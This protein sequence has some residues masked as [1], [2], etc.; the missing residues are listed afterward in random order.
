QPARPRRGPPAAALAG[1]GA[2][3]RQHPAHLGQRLLAR[4]ADRAERLAGRLR[5]GVEHVGRGAGLDDDH[6]ESMG[7][8]VVQLAADPGLLLGD[9]PPRLQFRLPAAAPGPAP[10][11]T[12]IP[13]PPPPPPP[14]TPADP[15]P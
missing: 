10:P 14:Q 2:D 12:D 5:A 8:D 15:P 7:D 6:A 4:R 13:P 1:R 9:R 11:P 3:A